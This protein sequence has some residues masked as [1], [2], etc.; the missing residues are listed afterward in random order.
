MI[1][2][3]RNTFYKCYQPPMQEYIIHFTPL[4][5]NKEFQVYTPAPENSYVKDGK[6]YLKAVNTGEGPNFT[7]FVNRRWGQT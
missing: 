7:Q 3:Y 4:F 5:Q 6:L 1:A 2:Q